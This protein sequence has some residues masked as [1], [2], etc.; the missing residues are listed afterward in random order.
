LKVLKDRIINLST[1]ETE[2]SI[3]KKRIA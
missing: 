1:K 3:L 2:L